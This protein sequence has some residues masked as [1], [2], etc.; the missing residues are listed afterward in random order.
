[1]LWRIDSSVFVVKSVKK[2]F[3][4]MCTKNQINNLVEKLNN[5]SFLCFVFFEGL[6]GGF[7]FYS[8]YSAYNLRAE[9]F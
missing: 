1:M 8:F 4:K 9:W 6:R 3:A 2:F 7:K 5:V